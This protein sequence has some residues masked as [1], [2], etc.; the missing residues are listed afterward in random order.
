MF[1]RLA[2]LGAL[3]CVTGSA[4]AQ[5]RAPDAGGY[6]EREFGAS[7]YIWGT[8]LHGTLDTGSGSEVDADVKFRDILKNTNI[9][10]FAAAGGRI[11]RFVGL[12]DGMWVELEGD[13]NSG[14][15]RV[16]PATAGPAELNVKMWQGVADL[17]GGYRILEPA[18]GARQPVSIDLLAGGRYVYMRNKADLD[19]AV[20]PDQSFKDSMDWIDPIVGARVIIGLT[21]RVQFAAIGDVGGWSAGTAS[22]R[23]YQV[24]GLLDVWLSQNWSFRLGY[25]TVSIERGS[26]DVEFRGPVVGTVYRF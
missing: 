26:M 11:G 16:G 12:F 13:K 19:F 8:E 17:K 18:V 3:L 2:L 5:D 20:L 25:K 21:P 7:L 10:V 6:P 14:T 24:T 22:D 1:Q 4:A 9:A 15:V 23:T